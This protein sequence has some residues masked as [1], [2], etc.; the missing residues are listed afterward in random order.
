MNS[1]TLQ[2]NRKVLEEFLM[3][4]DILNKVESKISNFNVF[5]TLRIIHTEIR[6]SNVLSWLL[7]P[8]ENHGFGDYIIKKVVETVVYNNF[9]DVSE[10]SYNPLKISLMDYHDFIIRREWRNIDILAVSEKNKFLI[11]FEN[12]VWSNESNHQLKKYHT[13]IN[14]EYRDYEKLFIYLTPFGDESSAPTIWLNMNYASIISIIENGLVI[15][16]EWMSERTKLFVE[17]Y[18]EVVRRYIVGDNELEKVC[19]EIYFKHK[20]ALDLIF[21]YKP[22]IYSDISNHLQNI[23][24]ETPGLILDISNKTYIRF[25]TDR[26]DELIPKIGEGWVST[27]RLLLFEFQNKSEKLALKLLIGPG[28]G[29]LREKILM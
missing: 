26:L 9:S 8:T 20:K 29:G 14:E 5:E 6:H 7:T 16:K 24:S 27:N 28:D 2:V 1:E 25:T 23:I 19:R 15:K 11:A 18:L 4:I 12:K 13:I 10:S 22:D 21:E 17:Q 3:D